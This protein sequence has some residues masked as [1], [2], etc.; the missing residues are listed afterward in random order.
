M[1]NQTNKLIAEIV[2]KS[3]AIAKALKKGD[4]EI[5]RGTN[6]IT[7]AEVKRRVITR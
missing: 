3:E 5:R 7:V 4:V 2:S 1:D 6:G